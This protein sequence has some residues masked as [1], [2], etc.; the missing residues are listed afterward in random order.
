M[1]ATR[2]GLFYAP[3][4]R[5]AWSMLGQFSVADGFW[6]HAHVAEVRRFGGAYREQ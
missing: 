5:C 1:A 4:W 6:V 2:N 3:L